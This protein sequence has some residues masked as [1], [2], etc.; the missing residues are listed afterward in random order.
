MSGIRNSDVIEFGQT[1]CTKRSSSIY[2]DLLSQLDHGSQ[3]GTQIG[4]SLPPT[5]TAL[6]GRPSA[7]QA[8][9][10]IFNS[11]P[12]DDSKSV[13]KAGILGESSRTGLSVFV[14]V[15]HGLVV[16]VDQTWGVIFMYLFTW[17]RALTYIYIYSLH[18]SE[19]RGDLTFAP[20]TYAT[21]ITS[22]HPKTFNNSLVIKLSALN[23]ADL[24]KVL[25]SAS[26][27][28]CKKQ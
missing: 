23:G 14:K 1:W 11:Y 22:H 7:A 17:E 24:H 19:L 4:C 20:K 16:G 6:H 28:L 8:L 13:L 15:N 12:S 25:T 10:T 18:G 27:C 26:P 5:A 2:L 21:R 9:P 3:C